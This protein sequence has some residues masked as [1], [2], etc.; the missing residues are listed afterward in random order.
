MIDSGML[1]Y[2]LPPLVMCMVL[3]A[4]HSYLG[5]HVIAREV[6]FVDLSLA[7]MAAL[8]G[9]IAVVAGATAESVPAAAA[10][11]GATA[12][13]AALFA[14]TR[15][16]GRAPVPHEAII[17]IV[18]VVASAATL[19]VADRAPRGAETIHDTLVGSIIWVTWP[20]I[21]NKSAIYAVLI[22]IHWLFRRRFVTISFD[23]QRAAA[24]GWNIRW[25]D[26]WF[27]A[28]FGVAVTLSVPVAGVLLVFTMLV[29]PATT[30]FLFT[31]E[32]RRLVVISWSTGVVASFLGL[33]LSYVGDLP[34]GPL[35]ICMY[36]ALLIGAASVRRLRGAAA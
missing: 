8:G 15:S 34:T 11:F 25:W 26:F 14:V 10:A 24:A 2:L 19:L 6:I 13:G 17:G 30:A 33:W 32:I 12:L 29:V 28:S 36:G 16:R 27:Y 7:Q 18:Y 21:I 31:R 23:P 20:V 9:V 1:Q 22:G 4:V 3:V 5:L 35:I